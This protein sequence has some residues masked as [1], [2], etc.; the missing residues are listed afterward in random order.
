MAELGCREH[1]HHPRT[2][3]SPDSETG[4]IDITVVAKQLVGEADASNTAAWR[5][6]RALHALDELA[7]QAAE[8]SGDA[9]QACNDALAE[10]SVEVLGQRYKLS[11]MEALLVFA[12]ARARATADAGRGAAHRRV[13]DSTTIAL[14]RHV[15]VISGIF[16]SCSGK[17]LQAD[18]R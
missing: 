8:I 3:L 7:R 15:D 6:E 16:A 9:E 18:H 2:Q 4:L 10:L 13:G 12:Q 5:K 17:I 14:R 11:R 1:F